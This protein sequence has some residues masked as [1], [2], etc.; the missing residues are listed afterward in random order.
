MRR[1]AA[2]DGLNLHHAE[3]P[4]PSPSQIL[5]SWLSCLTAS[6]LLLGCA[7]LGPRGEPPPPTRAGV[8]PGALPESTDRAQGFVFEDLDGDGVRDP[9]EPGLPGVRVSNGVDVVRTDDAG[10]WALPV[11]DDTILFVIKPRDWWPPLDANGL[12]RFYYVHK[13]AGSPDADFA[14]PGVAPTGPLPASIDFPLSRRPESDRFEVLVVGDP[15][16]YDEEQLGWYARDTVAELVGSQAAF[17]LSLG[18]LVGDDLSLFEGLNAVQG[19]VGI[20]WYNVIGNHDLNFHSPG[21]A[22]SDETFE[23]VYGPASYAFQVGRAHFVVL[24]DVLWGGFDGL[25]S[26]GRA[27][28]DNYAAGFRPDQMRFLE[29]L[30]ATIP[31]DELVVLAVH[32]PLP[33][34]AR[35]GAPRPQRVLELLS[36]HPHSLTLAGHTHRLDH[37][38][39]GPRDGFAPEGGGR[40]H[41]FVVGAASGN[42]WRGAPDELGIPHATMRDGAPN[43]YAVLEVDGHTYRLRYKASRRPADHQLSIFAPERVAAGES[44]EVVV[45][46]FAASR[47]SQVE[48]RVGEDAP[49]QP[50]EREGRVD[51]FYQAA[52]ALEARVDGDWRPLQGPVRSSHIWVGRLPTGLPPGRHWIE[53]RSRDRH[54]RVHLGSRALL[55]D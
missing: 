24:D 19:R 2:P 36:G 46:V 16:P 23:R 6:S 9:D 50:L 27:R 40:H 17:G 44:A 34:P 47:E 10:R 37:A 39:F 12:P 31:A 4:S 26:D 54:G 25:R 5:R 13:P 7:G 1:A 21:D 35:R 33:A 29:S 14:Y 48:L 45:N 8:A 18:D 38:F 42:R 53:V 22:H 51:P 30:L 15:Q 49:W 3:S 55:V 11:G 41:Q 28:N 43:G 32:I 20:P 52:R